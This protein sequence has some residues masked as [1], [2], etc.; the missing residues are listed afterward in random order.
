MKFNFL[1]HKIMANN[2]IK[3]VVATAMIATGVSAETPN[4]NSATSVAVRESS[5]D[6][7]QNITKINTQIAL[8][9]NKIEI[10]NQKNDLS[11]D[12]RRT[13]IKFRIELQ[14]LTTEKL[15]IVDNQNGHKREKV[16]I[17]TGIKKDI[18]NTI[19]KK[20]NIEKEVDKTVAI[21]DNS[22]NKHKKQLDMAEQK[23]AALDRVSKILRK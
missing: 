18:D 10:L 8:I 12:E 16:A 3:S 17:K 5:I 22:I 6:F 4:F 7:N 20:I 11:R 23:L 13:R 19:D 15:V 9:K 14:K 21:I 2:L 1:I